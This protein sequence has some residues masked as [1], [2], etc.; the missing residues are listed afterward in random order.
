MGHGR[1]YVGYFL[2]SM[3]YVRESLEETAL[4]E[5]LEETGLRVDIRAPLGNV[6]QKSGK[7]VHAFWAT[8]H[9]ESEGGIDDNG[10]CRCDHENDVCRFYRVDEARNLMIPAQR[11]LLDRLSEHVVA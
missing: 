10:R 3:G 2:R 5:T 9:P 1:L 11:E 7:I 4:R 8:V 6:R